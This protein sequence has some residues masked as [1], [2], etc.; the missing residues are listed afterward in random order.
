MC[1]IWLTSCYPPTR[2]K[3]EKEIRRK[4]FSTTLR[5]IT[6]HKYHRPSG[7]KIW[8]LPIRDIS[9]ICLSGWYHPS[10]VAAA[11]MGLS[12]IFSRVLGINYDRS[13]SFYLIY[14]YH[15]KTTCLLLSIKVLKKQ[16]KGIT[17]SRQKPMKVVLIM[18]QS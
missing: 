14:P 1:K 18:K 3:E 7:L 2:R 8:L 13:R 12:G 17:G 6:T 5:S 15:P 16:K 11:Q 10:E 9:P 4:L